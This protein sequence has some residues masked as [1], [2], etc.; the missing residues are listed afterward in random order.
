MRV[1]LPCCGPSFKGVGISGD[2]PTRGRSGGGEGRDRQRHVEERDWFCSH[3]LVMFPLPCVH[4]RR[5]LDL[6]G[7]P[8]KRDRLVGVIPSALGA[9]KPALPA[10]QRVLGVIC[11]SRTHHQRG[12]FP[13]AP[14]PDRDSL[15]DVSPSGARVATTCPISPHGTSLPGLGVIVHHQTKTTCFLA[16]PLFSCP[17][18]AATFLARRPVF[19]FRGGNVS[20]PDRCVWTM[21]ERTK[22]DRVDWTGTCR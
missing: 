5:C 3:P 6:F 4:R 14:F 7:T 12:F 1:R 22:L 21:G 9:R 19:C 16:G 13:T 18:C 8:K 10:G 17:P 15:P 2:V 11:P 20:V